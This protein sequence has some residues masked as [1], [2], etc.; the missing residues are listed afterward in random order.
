MKVRLIHPPWGGHPS[1]GNVF[2]RHLLMEAERRGFPLEGWSLEPG[3]SL[4]GSFEAGSVVLWDSLFL[5]R[6]AESPPAGAGARHALLVHYFPFLN[7]LLGPRESRAWARRFDQAVDRMGFLVATGQRAAK[8]LRRRYPETQVFL[9]EPGVAPEFP[10]ARHS[11][12]EPAA[13]GRVRIA[14]VANFLPA[15]GQLDLL[16]ILAALEH[17]DWEWHLAGDE[18]ADPDY[19]RQFLQQSSRLR[20]NQRIVRHGV[21]ETPDLARLLARMDLFAFP[22]RYEAYGMALAE[23]A[24]VGLPIVTTAVGEAARLVRHGETGFMVV[25][26]D[27]EAFRDALARLIGGGALRRRF[28]EAWIGMEPRIWADTFRQFEQCIQTVG[29]P[30]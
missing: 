21:L 23:A 14:T 15:K 8:V 22:S 5:D 30:L 28:C 27:G 6:L 16:E 19:T 29:P 12:R 3:G 10:A 7:P 25:P 4:P 11:P 1:G 18:S 9:C 20:L 24:A 17:L 13:G 2:N 26:G